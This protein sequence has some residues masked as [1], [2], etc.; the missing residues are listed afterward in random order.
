M[1]I[2]NMRTRTILDIDDDALEFAS[3]YAKAR[4]VS[5]DSAISELIRR[6]EQMMEPPTSA[7]PNLKRDA[8]GFL[9]V[10]DE[11]SVITAELVK[12]ESEDD[13]A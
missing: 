4:G 9:V 3:F 12:K 7:S 11:G 5:L 13:P 10:K 8:H 2:G 1:H 6:A